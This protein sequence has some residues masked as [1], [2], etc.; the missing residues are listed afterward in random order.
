MTDRDSVPPVKN[1]E[2]QKYEN[3]ALHCASNTD[4][5]GKDQTY[6]TRDWSDSSLNRC[7][8]LAF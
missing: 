8:D 5:L 6:V 3:T 4:S 2:M 1:V 7:L